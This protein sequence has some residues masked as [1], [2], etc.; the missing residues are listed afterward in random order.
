MKLKLTLA[1]KLLPCLAL[2][3]FAQETQYQ[4]LDSNLNNL[5]RVSD[6]TTRSISPENLTGEKGKGGMAK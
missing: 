2:P 5:Y 4:G 6:A 3:A 1:L